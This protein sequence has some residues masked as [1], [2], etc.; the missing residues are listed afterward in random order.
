M[1]GDQWSSG[2]LDARGSRRSGEIGDD[3]RSA[4]GDRARH[5]RTDDRGSVSTKSSKGRSVQLIRQLEGIESGR[6]LLAVKF[7][8]WCHMSAIGKALSVLAEN[9]HISKCF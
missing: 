2:D 5:G 7:T 9:H 3:L 4:R 8:D 6:D 1:A